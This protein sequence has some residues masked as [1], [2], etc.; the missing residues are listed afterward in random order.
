MGIDYTA[1]ATAE[2]LERRPDVDPS[3]LH[4][5]LRV[6]RLA[7]LLDER[8][9]QVAAAHG[10]ANYGDYEVM[11]VLRRST[12]DVSAAD[13]AR[14]LRLSP[15]GLTGRLN[16]LE[17]LGL[18]ER[19]AA[20]GDGRQVNARTTDAGKERTDEVYQASL[21]AQLELLTPLTPKQQTAL[22]NM[23]GRITTAHD[24]PVDSP[25]S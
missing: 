20:P 24:P 5:S 8:L 14:Q 19:H 25:E 17:R 11:A 23:L 6:R 7:G 16:R 18:V 12:V 2:W 13:L 10:L 21:D 3:V 15:A 22:G 4:I 1:Q 9:T